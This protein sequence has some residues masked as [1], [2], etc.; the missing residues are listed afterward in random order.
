MCDEKKYR[1]SREESTYLSPSATKCY[2][3]SDQNHWN[4]MTLGL[5]ILHAFGVVS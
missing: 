1:R 5:L 3:D 4:R 2:K